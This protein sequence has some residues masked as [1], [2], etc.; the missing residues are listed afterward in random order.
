MLK[1]KL[2]TFNELT[3]RELFDL[4]YLRQEVFVVEQDCPYQDADRKDLKSYHLMGYQ[5]DVLV[6]Y[7]RI[8]QPGVSYREVSIGR[9]V[10]KKSFRR[11]GTGSKLMNKGRE[12][13]EKI[14]GLVPIRISA[15]K[16]LKTFYEALGYKPTGK[17]YLE[18]NIPH[19]EMLYEPIS[20]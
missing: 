6:S 15:Q 7:L 19:I 18:D 12:E 17:E 20:I 1:W 5:G 4:Y 9:V 8:V 14:Y 13:L 2:K 3:V 11:K 10:T 16:Y